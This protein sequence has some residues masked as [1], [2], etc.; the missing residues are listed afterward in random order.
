MS[1]IRPPVIALFRRWAETALGMSLVLWGTWLISRG[2]WFLIGAG[3]LLGSFGGAWTLLAL[4][5]VRFQREIL[6]PGLVELDEGRLSY[7][8]PIRGGDVSLHDLAELH[9]LSA[10]GRL[11]WELIDLYGARLLVPLDAAG[12]A[13]LFDAFA[14]L[15]GLGSRDLVAA[16]GSAREQPDASTSAPHGITV[17]RRQGAALRHA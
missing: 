12:S 6:S 16:V 11:A 4:R 2:G 8:H 17:W 15:P 7:L 1:F 10:R 3:G 5:R 13:D 9:L 14:A